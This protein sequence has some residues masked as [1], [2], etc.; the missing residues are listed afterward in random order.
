MI[1][2]I[3]KQS[4]DSVESV[5]KKKRKGG[6]DLQKGKADDVTLSRNVD[7]FV[8]SSCRISCSERHTAH[9]TTLVYVGNTVTE[10]ANSAVI[11]EW[12]SS[13]V[14]LAHGRLKAPVA[15]KELRCYEWNS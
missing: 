15:V 13:P 8:N 7:V 5:Q 2:S 11:G 4:G 12:L 3:S 14:A 1:G 6:K 9:V 10:V